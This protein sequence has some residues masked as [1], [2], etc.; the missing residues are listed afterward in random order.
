MFDWLNILLPLL[1]L[2]AR[3]GAFL[4]VLPIFGWQSLPL[5][6]RGGVSLLMAWFF[7]Q[8]AV[9]SVS[10]ADV[11]WASAVLLVGREVLTGL[12]LGLAARLVYHAVRAGVEMG[13]QQMG[14]ADA[15]IFDPASGETAQTVPMLFDMLFM[16]LFLAA[17]GHRLLLVLIARSFEVFPVGSPPQMQMLGSALIAAGSE[18]LL[19]ALRLAA[20]VLAAFLLLSVLMG[21][22]ARLLPEM[23]ILFV[24][25]PIRVALGMFMAMQM[26][27]FL[28]NVT[29][30]ITR[31][32]DVKLVM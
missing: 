22:L 10:A 6:V 32:L 25:F 15:G 13:L 17:G 16:V 24:S 28:D 2:V 27:P 30:E 19:L 1:M 5:M 3:V 31:W 14:M 9:V 8:F 11:H 29:G 20:P 7:G 23:N 12:G 18:M 26:F 4:F 21:V